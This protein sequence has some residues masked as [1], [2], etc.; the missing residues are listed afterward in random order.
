V[1]VLAELYF[2]AAR[3]SFVI[4]LESPVSHRVSFLGTR[5]LA[6]CWR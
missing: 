3:S 6:E 1:L 4:Y 5:I 2:V